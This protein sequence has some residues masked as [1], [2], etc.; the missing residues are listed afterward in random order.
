M[1]M[2]HIIN[3]INFRKASH[4]QHCQGPSSCCF[5]F[6]QIWVTWQWSPSAASASA[7]AFP[8]AITPCK[9]ASIMTA[10]ARVAISSLHYSAPFYSTAGSVVGAIAISVMTASTEVVITSHYSRPCSSPCGA[11]TA[12]ACV[13]LWI[14]NFSTIII[15]IISSC[16]LS[17]R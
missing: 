15:A 10:P 3:Y 17:Y 2:A 14:I 16:T 13:D 1:K 6:P 8:I 12:H 5:L 4:Y 11:M 9:A 7:S